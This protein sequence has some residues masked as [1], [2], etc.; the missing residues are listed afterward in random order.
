[1]RIYSPTGWILIV[2]L[3]ISAVSFITYLLEPGFPDETLYLLL[4]IVRY[5]SFFVFLISF[6][7]LMK[8]GY[9]FI[10]NPSIFRFIKIVLYV[11]LILYGISLF[12]IESFITVISGGNT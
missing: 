9:G 4:V 7:K 2:S 1:M 6:Y 8:N 3:A 11:I 10:R 12:F 5:S